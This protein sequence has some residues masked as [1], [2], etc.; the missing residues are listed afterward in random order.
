MTKSFPHSLPQ[1]VGFSWARTM[2]SPLKWT[3][4]FS[5]RE[6]GSRSPRPSFLS[7]V[8]MV[9]ASHHSAL[10]YLMER[11][12]SESSPSVCL[13]VATDPMGSGPLRPLD[14]TEWGALLGYL[15]EGA[16]CL[17]SAWL[18]PGS[19]VWPRLVDGAT[20]C[21]RAHTALA[22]GACGPWTQPTI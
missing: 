17:P 6:Q 13:R 7:R 9:R 1:P 18:H 12:R 15:P 11:H 10:R 20:A 21:P 3:I 4:E 14:D 5:V 16:P 8:T 2:P 19:G 22:R